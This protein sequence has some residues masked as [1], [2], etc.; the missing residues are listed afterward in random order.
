[1]WYADRKKM[2]NFKGEKET[3]K[4]HSILAC[5]YGVLKSWGL[6]AAA[7][8]SKILWFTK[9]AYLCAGRKKALFFH[10]KQKP[11]LFCCAGS[12]QRGKDLIFLESRKWGFFSPFQCYHVDY[13]LPYIHL[14]QLLMAF[15]NL[16]QNNTLD[17]FISIWM[18]KIVIA[19]DL[20]PDSGWKGNVYLS[21]HET[22]AKIFLL[23][24][25][26]CCKDLS[27]ETK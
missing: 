9:V 12:T 20:A 19:A 27:S 7:L 3:L 10:S 22:D 25:N 13:N 21:K 17:T 11:W 6:I 5:F 8:H 18:V 15:L 26:T 23:Q 16:Y 2:V 14:A 24:W 4:I 1:M